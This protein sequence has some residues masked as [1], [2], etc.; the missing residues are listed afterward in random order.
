MKKLEKICLSLGLILLA[1]AVRFN[2]TWCFMHAA[3]ALFIFVLADE[4]S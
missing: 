4:L 1:T 2:D 3:I